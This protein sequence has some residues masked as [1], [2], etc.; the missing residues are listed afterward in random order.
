MVINCARFML[1]VNRCQEISKRSVDF[2]LGWYESSI[3]LSFCSHRGSQ[4]NQQSIFAVF[5]CLVWLDRRVRRTNYLKLHCAFYAVVHLLLD[6]QKE[7]IHKNLINVLEPQVGKTNIKYD[8][9]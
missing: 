3:Y 8:R 5:K 9:Y 1:L 6:V 2:C 4:P 7:D